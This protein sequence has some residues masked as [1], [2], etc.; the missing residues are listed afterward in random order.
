MNNISNKPRLTRAASFMAGSV[1]IL[2]L[3]ACGGGAGADAVS[4]SNAEA[5]NGSG[6]IKVWALDGQS[7]ENAAIQKI[8]DDFTKTSGI[9][10]K[11]QFIPADSF[12]KTVETSAPEDLPDV[13]EVDGPVIANFAYNKRIAPLSQFLAADTIKNQTEAIKGQNTVGKDLYAVGMM[14]S[15]LAMWG[16][17]KQ[18]DAAGVT[19]PTKVQDAWTAKEFGEVLAKLAKTDPDGKPFGMGEA[20]GLT[21]EYGIYAFAPIVWSAGTGI[22]KDG[23]ATG[24]LDSPQ[25]VDATSTFA[26]WRKYTDP[27]TNGTAFQSGKVALNWMGNWLYP[28][29]KKALGDDLVVGPLPDFGQGAKT[30][31]GTIAW[32]IGG[33]TKNGAAAGK[34]LDYLMS[35][36]VVAQYTAANGAPP[37]TKS[38]LKASALYGKG[39]PLAFL[40]SQ[41]ESACPTEDKLSKECVAV[42]RPITPGYPIITAEFGK[43]LG[44]IWGGADASTSLQG[45]ARA[46]D[47]N[48]SDNDNF[49]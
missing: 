28:A 40:A 8:V 48:F 10:V 31:S 41:L 43:A 12:Q 37:A 33:Y 2:L 42:S 26:S 46:I 18:L 44:A 6:P 21:S 29:Y 19:M 9:T 34:L 23:K 27:D 24:S 15:G 36:K 22:L 30:G 4:N 16:N 47:R 11:M 25:A 20:N 13:L 39:G 38:A 1:A 35:D 17:K 7:A 14:N 32:S 5:G 45:A 49:R 3:A